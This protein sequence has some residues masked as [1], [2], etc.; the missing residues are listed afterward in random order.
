MSGV[1]VLKFAQKQWH[2]Q[3]IVIKAADFTI[4]Q[5]QELSE[6]TLSY[7]LVL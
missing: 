1:M 5:E 6:S 3:Q 7:S 4:C 2:H